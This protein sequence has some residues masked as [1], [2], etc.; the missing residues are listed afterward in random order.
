MRCPITIL[1]VVGGT[2]I[3]HVICVQAAA[4]S[5]TRDAA[6]RVHLRDRSSQLGVHLSPAG[7]DGL[8]SPTSS[9]FFA[10]S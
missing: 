2:A 7:S 8:T 4:W 1:R 3:S 10:L 9:P 6:F 5:V